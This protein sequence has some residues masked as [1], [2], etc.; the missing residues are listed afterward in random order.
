MRTASRWAVARLA[1]LLLLP[2]AAAGQDAAAPDALTLEEAVRQALER[3]PSR[4]LSASGEAGA[5]A[6]V[7]EAAAARLPSLSLDASLNRFQEPMVVAPLHGFDPARPPVFDRTLLQGSLTLAYTLFDAGAREARLEGAR[8]RAAAASHAGTA[9]DQALIRDVARSYLAALTAR[10]VAGAIRSRVAALEAER[11]RAARLHEAGRAPR[12]ALLRADAALSAARA[13]ARAAELEVETTARELARWT[14]ESG[15]L[16]PA[17]PLVPLRVVRGSGL[18]DAASWRAQA[19]RHSGELAALGARL[20]A[21]EA[22][23]REAR[24]LW[25]PRVQLLGR[26]VEYGS[27]A[28]LEGSGW[29]GEWQAGLLLSQPLL[30]G[31]AR[32]AAAD[33][34]AAEREGTR[35]ELAL[36]VLRLDA[37]VDRAVAVVRAERSRA[38]A[39]RVAV[40]QAAEVARIER[41]SLEEGAG[42]QTDYLAAEAELLR[43][44]SAHAAARY[45]E[46]AA[47]VEL[48]RAAGRLTPEWL[49]TELEAGS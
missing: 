20:A 43:L 35:A 24:S 21:T 45:A 41:L 40:E 1:A 49:G 44:R 8:S 25:Y 30:T 18:P 4:A 12:V 16:A 48:A 33:R 2:G 22:G 26:Y 36:A 15:D 37:A 6:G 14:G 7:R 47:R 29:Q 19:R 10:E 23:A 32:P 3:H 39:L 27:G 17:R 42:L 13:E 38:E 28:T 11:A 34:A 5:S 9:T 31:G 46:V